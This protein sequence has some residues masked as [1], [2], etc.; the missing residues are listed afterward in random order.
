MFDAPLCEKKNVFLV[1]R[2]TTDILTDACYSLKCINSLDENIFN[3]TFKPHFVMSG[4]HF[5]SESLTQ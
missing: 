5:I 1:E 2:E 4:I 3:S